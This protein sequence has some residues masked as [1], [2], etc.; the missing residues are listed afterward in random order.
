M[1]FIDIDPDKTV[2]EDIILINNDK[3]DILHFHGSKRLII[4]LF[5]ECTTT[6]YDISTSANDYINAAY[7]KNLK[8]N[9]FV[10]DKYPNIDESD[11]EKMLIS[12]D[13]FFASKTYKLT[14]QSPITLPTDLITGLGGTLGLFV[15][16]SFLSLLEVFDFFIAVFIILAKKKTDQ[17]FFQN[18]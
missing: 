10:K 13:I 1:L 8:Q 5:L 12:F 4:F 9:T 2:W 17:M 6:I 14:T 15:G 11:L 16:A 18:T 7:L 3:N